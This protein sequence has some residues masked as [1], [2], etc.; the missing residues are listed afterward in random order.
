M[1]IR[2][3]QENELNEL[4][5][6]YLHLHSSDDSSPENEVV[7]S[8]WHEIKS[9]PNLKYFGLYIKGKLV[10]SCTIIIVPNLTRGFR[11]YGVIE[12]VV[13]HNNFRRN[14]YGKAIL[15]HALKYAWERNCYKVMLQTGR[16]DEGTYQFYES[17]G[18]DRYA[19]KAFLAKPPKNS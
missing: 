8:I 9:N 10:S 1:E 3:V 19:K 7:K 16:K 11:P 12:N 15:S 5:K 6:L 17:V 14:S 2:E 13:T 18:F 4:L